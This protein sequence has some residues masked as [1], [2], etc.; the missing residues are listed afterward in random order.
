MELYKLSGTVNDFRQGVLARSRPTPPRA[1]YTVDEF[2]GLESYVTRAYYLAFV[3][4]RVS[5]EEYL[6]SLG[7]RWARRYS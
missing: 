1:F 6:I 7:T 3:T 5:A 2:R 4:H